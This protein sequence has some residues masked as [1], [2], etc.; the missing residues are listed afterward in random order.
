MK[1]IIIA[2]GTISIALIVC[3][4]CQKEDAVAQNNDQLE[5]LSA[6]VEDGLYTKGDYEISGSTAAFSWVSGDSFR[7]IVR[8]YD[9]ANY[10]SY[11]YYTYTYSTGSGSTAT[12]T[13]SSVGSAYV[14][15]G[16][17]LTPYDVIMYTYTEHDY[18]FLLTMSNSNTYNVEHPLRNVVPLWGEKAGSTYTFKPLTGVIAVKLTN[19]P[20]ST[21]SVKLSST[22]KGLSGK[23]ARFNNT[24]DNLFFT[25]IPE[26]LGN[27]T[28][29]LR[30]GWMTNGNSKTFTFAASSFVSQGNEATFYF[31]IATS[32]DTA[33]NPSPYTNFTVTISDGET[34]QVITKTGLS[35]TVSRGEIVVLPTI[36]CNYI[37]TS[38]TANVNGNADDIKVYYTKTK[39]T[40]THVRAAVLSSKSRSALDA[41][42][43]NNTSG[44][45]ILTATDSEN[46][47]SVSGFSAS[48]A[49]YIGVK[50]FNGTTEV[51]SYIVSNPVYYLG[52]ATRSS[53]LKQF[54]T[55]GTS[56]SSGMLNGASVTTA[57]KTTITFALSNDCTKGNIMVNEFA[58]NTFTNPAYGIFDYAT[59]QLT[60]KYDSE[61]EN[62]TDGSSHKH[63]FCQGQTATLGDTKTDIVLLVNDSTVYSPTKWQFANGYFIYDY[64]EDSG[65]KSYT[66][67]KKMVAGSK[68][69]D[70]TVD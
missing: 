24:Q 20:T 50:A 56:H 47:I 46:A 34:E 41:A 66:M 28:L 17:A 61:Q 21:T 43:P 25:K 48:G 52:S 29:G 2:F 55:D 12:F 4:S 39:G 60:I 40:V 13:G 18:D 14:D 69:S 11:A 65:R 3:V 10:G 49:Y 15:A 26:F 53:M 1:K 67:I 62:Y 27:S 57:I 35:V 7:R 30:K 37:G 42:I 38:L 68:N 64:Y 8:S 70:L 33:G 45:D 19:I 6:I 51:A 59:G 23:S 16:F 9:G 54:S 58:G 36:N 32:Y 22:D 44:T 63:Y 5:T 31:P